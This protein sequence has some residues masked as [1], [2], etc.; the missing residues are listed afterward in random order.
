MLK[1]LLL[2]GVYPKTF[3]E[4]GFLLNW[5]IWSLF[6]CIIQGERNL[7]IISH[8]QAIRKNNVYVTYIFLKNVV[9]VL[10]NFQEN[11]SPISLNY[12]DF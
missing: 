5:Q 7:K 3:G 6:Q 9:T 4:N 1:T 10:S 8:M 11:F 12:V 2:K